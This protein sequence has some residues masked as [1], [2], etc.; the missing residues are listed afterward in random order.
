MGSD[1]HSP[2]HASHTDFAFRAG[3]I[4]FL[5]L[6]FVVNILQAQV[7][8]L[9]G[10][11][12]LSGGSTFQLTPDLPNSAGAV[13]SVNRINLLQPVDISFRA[14]FG[15]K[16]AL[17]GHGLAFVMQKSGQQVLGQDGS[18]FGYRGI[19]PS[20]A[21]CFDTYEDAIQGDPFFDHLTLHTN[22]I[23]NHGP[24]T[25]TVQASLGSFNIEDGLWHTI[26]VV[27]NPVG[28]SIQVYFDGVLRLNASRDL[29]N[30]VFGGTS[31]VW[32]G[33][34][35]STGSASNLQ[36]VQ[37][38]Q[39]LPASVVTPL[40]MCAG[41]TMQVVAPMGSSYSW[42][43][44]TGISSTTVRSPFLYPV[45]N[46]TY[47]LS[48]TDTIGNPVILTVP[49]NVFPL[50]TAYN[51]YLPVG[52]STYCKGG[53][54][55]DISLD[56]SQTT[57]LYDLLLNGA[58][59]WPGVS[60]NGSGI[61]FGYQQPSG[62][63]TSIGTDSITRC[64]ARM[65]GGVTI[66]IDSLPLLFNVT[67]A[68]SYC[69]FGAGRLLGLDGSE[70][71]VQYTL[72]RSGLN[73]ITTVAGTGSAISFGYQQ[74]A[75][76]YTVRAENPLTGCTRWMTGTATVSILPLPTVTLT[77]FTS[78]C[79]G[80]AP[81]ALSGGSP[82]GGTYSGP[83]V[84]QDTLFNTAL[85]GSIPITYAYTSPLNGCVNTAV[86]SLTLH[87]LPVPSLGQDTAFCSGDS[88]VLQTSQAYTT[89][90][91][92][93]GSFSPAI[94]IHAP[95]TYH[96]TVTNQ[97]TCQA[98][99]TIYVSMHA[100]PNVHFT[101]PGPFCANA[102]PQNLTQGLPAGGTYTGPGVMTG[103]FYPS[104]IGSGVYALVYAYTDPLTS[105]LNR[106][107]AMVTVYA[108]P[109]LQHTAIAAVCVSSPAFQLS[110]GLPAGGTYSGSGV[111]GGYFYPATGAGPYNLTYTYTNPSTNCTQSIPVPLT[112][113]PLPVVQIPA[114]PIVCEG[115]SAIAL[116]IGIP[117]GGTYSGT[118]VS[119]TSF[120]PV[121]GPGPYLI[122]YH[123]TDPVSLCTDSAAALL[124]VRPAPNVSLTLPA[125]L[126][127]GTTPIFL[128][129][130]APAGGSYSGTFVNAGAFYPLLAGSYPVVYAYQDPLTT[131][132]ASARDTMIVHPLP[133]VSLSSLPDLCVSSPVIT[134]ANGT[135]GGGTFTGSG[136][137]AGTF[138]P[139]T[140]AGTYQITYHY[141]DTN[142]CQD[143]ALTSLVVHPL[144]VIT[145]LPVPDYCYDDLPVLLT[146]GNPATGWYSGAGV[147]GSA[148]FPADTGTH[149]LFYHVADS[150]T[151]CEDS[152]AIMVRV[153]PQ[154]VV[155]F[156]APP[157]V[158][159]NN[160][161]FPLSGGLP[162]G[163][164]YGGNGVVAGDFYAA[165]GAGNHIIWYAYTDPL[166]GCGDTVFDT[167]MVW[168]LPQVILS[169][170]GP[171]CA[172][173]P[174]T[175]LLGGQPTG[176]VYQG[177]GILNDTFSPF[178]AG[179]GNHLISYFFEDTSTGCRDTAFGHIAVYPLPTITLPSLP[180][181]C[182]NAV[183]F[184]LTGASPAGGTWQG[185]GISGNSFIPTLADTGYH[186]LTYHYADPL[187]ACRDSLT[188]TIQVWP[189]PDVGFLLDTALCD[190]PQSLTL[191]GG[192]PV[193]GSY[194]GSG[195]SAGV[196]TPV[197][198]AGSYPLFY[199]RE[200]AVTACRDTAFDTLL[201]HPLPSVTFV[202]PP[203][204]CYGSPGITLNTGLPAG[205]TYSGLGVT[206]NIFDP[207]TGTGAFHIT[208]AFQDPIT[209]CDAQAADSLMVF[210]LPVVTISPIGP[211]C[212]D[213]SAV[214]LTQGSPAG[215]IW[216][217]SGVITNV[218]H[219][220]AGAGQHSIW[221]TWTDS[222]TQCR[223]TA[224]RLVIVHEVPV[225]QIY[226]PEPFCEDD[227]PIPLTGSSPAG[228]TYT[229]SGIAG[230]SFDPG[231]GSGS[232]TI[233]YTYVSPQTGCQSSDTGVFTVNPL[234]LVQAGLDI[235]LCE[236]T[237]PYVM[238]S[239]LPPGGYWEGP[240]L[241]ADTFL[242][243]GQGVYQMVYHY[244][245]LTTSCQASDTLEIILMS[246]PDPVLPDSIEICEQESYLIQP[247][248]GYMA[249]YW[250]DG[251]N[252]PLLE[253]T[254][255]G[256]YWLQ[257]KD[258]NGC[259]S[260]PDTF[261]AI[262]HPLPDPGLPD[263]ITGCRNAAVLL[264]ALPGY[265]SYLWQDGSFGTE[266][267]VY[268]SGQ[269]WLEVVDIHGCQ[270]RDTVTVILVPSPEV[271]LPAEIYLC[272]RPYVSLDVSHPGDGV[273]YY[274]SDGD[275]SAL[276]DIHLPGEYFVT[277]THGQCQGWGGISILPC[278]ELW[279]PNAF[280]PNGDGINEF[281]RIFSSEPL[282]SGKLIILNRWGQVV[283]SA[284]NPEAEWDGTYRGLLC[285][286][287][288][289]TWVLDYRREG[290]VPVE[291]EGR[292]VG[293]VILL[294]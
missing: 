75:G 231:Q 255:A 279:A 38:H 127:E 40:R 30:D 263:E 198:G 253:V 230:N 195:V 130:G 187:T 273:R 20:V 258:L 235:Y 8:T 213:D 108:L 248:P 163:G 15:T 147:T 61:S 202:A 278:A 287:D 197:A 277:V 62:Y 12:S 282:V 7:F 23:V 164:T 146:G 194:G 81:I 124:Q 234:P 131:C 148:F 110:G 79:V 292:R 138:N 18:G 192:W 219:P 240:Y 55:I 239:G 125:S 186:L 223:D 19:S 145:H 65:L 176:G 70:P 254:Q 50:P 47:T 280:S 139:A 85:P 162:A 242:P 264:E 286:Q 51:L 114:L 112:V 157:P 259:F 53:P 167:L 111:S 43:P 171:F 46:T 172:S 212:E 173:D 244:T 66:V 29:I 59:Y 221:Y 188:G 77:S 149:T 262:V 92:S 257:V 252:L 232:H 233:I 141:L 26:R 74:V 88:L 274:W 104:N 216:G 241:Q 267:I 208:Y 120:T 200:D 238:P 183:P 237:L 206:G 265:V 134:L 227:P 3:W 54:G 182:V 225:V 5:C 168:P 123:Y 121:N 94:T 281:F 250:S 224:Y 275:T 72:F 100:L 174:D 207:G 154:P 78:A 63:Y 144:P 166:T 153:H 184:A 42:S 150:A 159:V 165:T 271:K 45:S 294:R 288:V 215:G 266:L 24:T 129:Q 169:L 116:P 31:L 156:S 209:G 189:L 1:S 109:V 236:D 191:T 126:C 107:T 57:V 22:G 11:A 214:T 272:N 289:Y 133:V 177:T 84:W 142:G 68:G 196:F 32:W 71:G 261:M 180:S 132:S 13:W 101:P 193:G 122:R 41:D 161:P 106:D 270:A 284:D 283:F 203:D 158:C 35:A 218:F 220:D 34:T 99:D 160:P 179:F 260:E 90:A 105:C 229:G 143:S 205:G 136:V 60:G 80:A 39:P 175:L 181:L 67:G 290:L 128:N 199:I 170:P 228:G 155:S 96:V 25:P 293:Q 9:K 152:I 217:G 89:Y 37:F 6:L 44:A 185:T 118:G 76:N 27:W 33:I 93:Q 243:P 83:G 115:D 87:A 52:D 135:P 16:D 268:A 226:V 102:G 97:Y 190:L 291:Q 204:V 82:S 201:V 211:F 113:H 246:N 28:T 48:Y 17:G 36:Q 249:Y 140:G 247:F 245:E 178:L 222:I 91:W 269:Y 56:G 276:R 69:Q 95:G 49:V 58:I 285:P 86:S 64:S 2:S 14:N 4:G 256:Q 103:M 119:G 21:L 137:N 210:P 10:T 251:S 73:I 98:S 151:A 117:A